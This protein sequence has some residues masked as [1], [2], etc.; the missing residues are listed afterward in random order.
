MV[1]SF[2]SQQILRVQQIQKAK[3]SR[4]QAR[5]RKEQ[6]KGDQNPSGKTK[7]HGK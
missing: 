4:E 5:T 1:F 2:F 7:K 3:R 6:T